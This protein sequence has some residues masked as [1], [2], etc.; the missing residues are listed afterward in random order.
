MSNVVEL[1]EI[2]VCPECKSRFWEV[3]ETKSSGGPYC[4][5][6]DCGWSRAFLHELQERMRAFELA[7]HPPVRESV[8]YIEDPRLREALELITKYSDDS[9]P[10]P[11]IIASSSYQYGVN[12]MAK[13]ARAAL[14]ER[15][16][17]TEVEP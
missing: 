13:I 14:D 15:D 1:E 7:L 8:R 11:D 17:R 4:R 16:D 3:V 12:D 9:G 6:S 5:C 2:S 10:T